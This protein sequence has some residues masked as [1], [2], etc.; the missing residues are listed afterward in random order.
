MKHFAIRYHFLIAFLLPLSLFASDPDGYPRLMQGPMIGAVDESSALIW[1][2]GSWTWPVN[3]IYSKSHDMTDTRR[4]K[5]VQP[6]KEHDYCLTIPLTGLEPDTRY[7]Y[8]VEIDGHEGEYRAQGIVN[9][10]RA[11][12][13]FG[14][15]VGHSPH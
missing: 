13:C 10:S 9:P 11:P 15:L 5:P 7:Y 14:T 4:T 12:A 6:A 8:R 1:V 3:I 2:R